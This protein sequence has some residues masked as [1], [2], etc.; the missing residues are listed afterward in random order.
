[1]DARITKAE[2]ALLLPR[3]GTPTV[4]GGLERALRR[5]LARLAEWPARRRAVYEL[6]RLDARQLA[7]IGLARED[8]AAV[9]DGHFRRRR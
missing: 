1:M 4:A 8:I 6:E 9:V 3:A 5:L 2:A 7:D